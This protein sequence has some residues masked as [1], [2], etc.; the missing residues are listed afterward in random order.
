VS[1]IEITSTRVVGLKTSLM[2]CPLG[3]QD[4]QP[5]F[6]WRMDSPRR[7]AQQRAF[8][9]FAASSREPLAAG[10]PDLW[11]SGRLES[12]QSVGIRYAGLALVSRQRCYWTVAVWDDRGQ[13]ITPAEPTW[14]ETGLLEPSD[15]VVTMEPPAPDSQTVGYAAD[16]VGT[17][18][19][20]HI[21]RGSRR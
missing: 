17:V 16:R 7:E 13:S 6:S 14:L 4:G 18:A 20:S 21:R 19:Q 10:H 11:D 3:L 15:W 8:R 5:T 12:T 2:V 1:A 9:V